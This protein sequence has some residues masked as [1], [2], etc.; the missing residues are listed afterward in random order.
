MKNMIFQTGSEDF[1]EIIESGAYYDDKTAYLN[2]LF[3]KSL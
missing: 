3:I 1:S 2:D